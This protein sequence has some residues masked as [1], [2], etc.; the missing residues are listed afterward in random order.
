[1]LNKIEFENYRCFKKSSLDLRD[2]AI[3][4]GKNNAG[5]STIIEALRLIAAAGKKSKSAIY[6]ESPKSLGIAL[7]NEGFV[8]DPVK[9]RI[10]LRVIIHFYD[11]NS[12][13]KIIG[14]FSDGVI[15]NIYLDT[16]NIFAV[17]TAPNGSII[18]RKTQAQQLSIDKI[19]ILPQIGLIK[20]N[21]KLLTEETVK[22]DKDTYLSSRHFRNEL[23]LFKDEYFND[24]KSIAEQTWPGLRIYD[25]E[26]N[27]NTDEFITLLVQDSDFPAEIGLMGSGLQMWLQI[28]WFI[29]RCAGSEIIILDEPDVYMHP[30]MQRKILDIV[31]GRYQQVII[32]THSVEIISAVDARNIVTVDKAAKKMKYA[33]S[34]RAVQQ[35]IDSIGSIHNLALVRLTNSKKC[36]FVEGKDMKILAKLKDKLKLPASQPIDTLPCIPLGGASKLNEAFGASKL[37]YEEA[38]GGIACFCILDRDYFTDE[39]IAKQ[40][41][42]AQDAHLHLHIW[43][44]KE[45]ENYLLIPK[46]IFRVVDKPESEYDVFLDRFHEVIETLKTET[47]LQYANQLQ[48]QDGKRKDL[49]SYYWEAHA[50]VDSSWNN[51]EEKLS[52][53][54]GKRTISL[55]NEWVKNEYH[56]SCSQAKIISEIQPEEINA[57]MITV[58]KAICG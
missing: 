52:I 27:R 37:F 43:Q 34:L 8:I 20:E 1:M 14:Y 44:K 22:S 56:K 47:I 9:L 28:I 13:A 26:Y 54:S 32:A 45:I 5:K 17:I 35:I 49:G 3:I 50:S 4:V 25:F 2:I 30:D 12:I 39:Y 19:D 51:L 38:K 15:I 24:F 58:L 41:Q 10:D 21:E 7:N 48:V 31:I 18:S 6:K 46:A 53:V 55:I 40:I 57:E 11:E 42:N 33:N 16:E 23:L 36:L 29:A